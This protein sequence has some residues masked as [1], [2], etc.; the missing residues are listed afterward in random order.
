MCN[1]CFRPKEDLSKMDEMIS[2][3]EALHSSVIV[4]I[5][6]QQTGSFTLDCHKQINVQ[7]KDYA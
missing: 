2:N 7:V 3:T 4:V 5:V 6:Q 1:I